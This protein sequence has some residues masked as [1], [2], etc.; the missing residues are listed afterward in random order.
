MWIEQY[1][2]NFPPR[3]G[4]YLMDKN[5]KR[6]GDRYASTLVVSM[7]YYSDQMIPT[8]KHVMPFCFT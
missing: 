7:Q 6:L 4:L 1:P 8:L 2:K 5:Q 3:V